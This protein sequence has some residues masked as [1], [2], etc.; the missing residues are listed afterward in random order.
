M[1]VRPVLRESELYVKGLTNTQVRFSSP[2]SLI[3][4]VT[5]SDNYPKRSSSETWWEMGS[6]IGL[7]GNKTSGKW[8]WVNNVTA[9]TL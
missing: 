8:I 3:F 2:V 6:W 7:S 1:T 9:G 4:Q 5:V